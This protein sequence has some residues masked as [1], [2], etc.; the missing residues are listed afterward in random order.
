MSAAPGQ[1]E[2]S[3]RR[4]VS[5]AVWNSLTDTQKMAV[6]GDEAGRIGWTGQPT[7]GEEPMVVVKRAG[8][9]GRREK[10]RAKAKAKEERGVAVATQTRDEGWWSWICRLVEWLYR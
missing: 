4:G 5:A 10:R 3:T 2:G 7:T 1:P 8:R 6:A 9:K